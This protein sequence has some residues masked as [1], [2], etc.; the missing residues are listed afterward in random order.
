MMEAEFLVSSPAWPLCLF[1][2]RI[3]VIAL[4]MLSESAS[5]A[6]PLMEFTGL[7]KGPYQELLSPN[8]IIQ[9][10]KPKSTTQSNGINM[11]QLYCLHPKPTTK[12]QIKIILRDTCETA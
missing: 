10:T 3:G 9:N 2:S 8:K 12:I 11:N 7:I 4:K 5:N 6:V 1:G